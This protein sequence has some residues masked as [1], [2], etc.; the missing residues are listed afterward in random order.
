MSTIA[1]PA[2][3]VRPRVAVAAPERRP[4][5]A[6]ETVLA[7]VDVHIRRQIRVSLDAG[8]VL[9]VDAGDLALV[10]VLD[11]EVR[12]LSD[13]GSSCT[14]RP[15]G[16]VSLSPAKP[17][18]SALSAGD[19]LLSTR[20]RSLA[21]EARGR[22]RILL[23]ALDL[24]DGSAHVA[25]L[26]PERAFV[27]GF[28][29]LEP[30]AAALAQHMGVDRENACPD[31]EGDLTI[32]RMMSRTVLASVIRAWSSNGCAP[33]GWPSLSND[34]F[35]D[36]VVD[37][38]QAE[39]GRD[40]SLDSL[41]ALGAMSRSVFAERFRQAFGRSPLGYVTDVRM[42]SA[43]ELLRRGYSVSEISRELGYGSDEG[44]SRAFRRHT[45]M[46]PSAWRA[47]RTAALPA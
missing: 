21:L 5:A 43:Q 45:G 17:P 16:R 29:T 11:G 15:T 39:P 9:P 1:A 31:R 13:G 27:T 2:P 46:T 37:A 22:A 32:C 12:I 28:D 24:A 18:L 19:V 30:A 44:F 4:T 20:G 14:I 23:S 26:L 36:R 33:A 41:A 10:Y 38:I 40:W 7:A 34:P 6:L 35:L 25:G 47:A 3:T 8:E 42:R